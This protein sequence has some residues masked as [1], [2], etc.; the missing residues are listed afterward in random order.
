MH[1]YMTF[2]NADKD[3]KKE[4]FYKLRYFKQRNKKKDRM[5]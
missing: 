2:L 4:Q 5:C 1:T 3:K